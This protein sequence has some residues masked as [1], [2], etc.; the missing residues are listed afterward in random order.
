MRTK[1][2]WIEGPWTGR[3]AILLR[4]R[5]ADWLED[6]VGSWHQAGIDAI[7]SVLTPD[8]IANFDLA[9]EADPCEASGIQFLSFPIADRG[10]PLSRQDALTFVEALEEYLASGK[11]VGIHCRQ[12][13]GRSALIAACL[14]TLAGISA[15]EAFQ[16]VSQAR[17]CP[18]PETPEQRKWVVEF[19][20]HLRSQ[21]R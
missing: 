18:V 14:L 12:G 8:E 1:P 7:V 10:T 19:A 4:P 21:P 11:N 5:G 2:F 15:E 9:Q 13:V 6:E 17:G 20:Q 3:L 16:R